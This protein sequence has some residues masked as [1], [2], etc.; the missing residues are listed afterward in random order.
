MLDGYPGS[1]TARHHRKVFAVVLSAED[2]ELIDVAE[3]A[4][5]LFL[6]RSAIVKAIKAGKLTASKQGKKWWISV[7]TL[8]SLAAEL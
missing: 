4:R 2:D 8:R 1:T 7:K 3:A 6:T 5:R